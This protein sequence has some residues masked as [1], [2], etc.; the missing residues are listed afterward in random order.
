[1]AAFFP[2]IGVVQTSELAGR[3]VIRTP[4]FVGQSPRAAVI[5]GVMAI[6]D[7]AHVRDSA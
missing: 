1:M 5:L 7:E 4:A 2:T 6:F 3:R